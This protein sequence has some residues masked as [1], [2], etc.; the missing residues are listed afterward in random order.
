MAKI[1]TTLKGAKKKKKG[2]KE[3]LIH[4]KIK[5]GQQLVLKDFWTR[6]I[7]DRDN[8]KVVGPEQFFAK[9]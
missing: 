8:L 3:F 6:T 2:T 4:W 7:L 9:L 1:S 5:L